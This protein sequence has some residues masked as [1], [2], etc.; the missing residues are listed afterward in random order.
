M[1]TPRTEILSEDEATALI[2]QFQ[3]ERANMHAMMDKLVA[4]PWR[5]LAREGLTTLGARACMLQESLPLSRARATV[6][7]YENLSSQG[8]KK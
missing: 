8:T 6:R 5:I 2:H 7:A 4:V 3:A 1:T